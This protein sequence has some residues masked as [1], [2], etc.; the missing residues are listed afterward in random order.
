MSKTNRFVATIAG[1]ALSAALIIAHAAGPDPR[2]TAA[3]GDSPQACATSGCH[4]GTALNGGGGNVVVNFQNGQTYTP[5][6]Q[7]TFTIVIT[8]SRARVYGFQ[9]T[10]RLESN[11]ASGQA[12]DFTAGAQQIVLCDNGSLK[13]SRG[14]PTN[15][16]V[17]F[18]EHGLPFN[19]NTI[20]VQWT[21]RATNV[22]NVHIYVAANAANGDGNNTG[23]HIYTANYVLTPQTTFNH[24]RRDKRQRLQ[25]ERWSGLRHLARNLWNKSVHNYSRLG[26]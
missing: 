22:G 6:G 25:S 15:S 24:Q 16:P 9:M 12:G 8:D 26:G 23:D 2:Y 11:L 1:V 3:P 21:A 19:T 14:C 4:T 20:S 18:I 5:G 10:A 13:G 17:Q 7:Q